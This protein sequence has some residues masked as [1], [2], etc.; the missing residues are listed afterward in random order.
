MFGLPTA[1]SVTPTAITTYF[2]SPGETSVLS[3]PAAFFAGVSSFYLGIGALQ[4][5]QKPK[6]CSLAKTAQDMFVKTQMFMPRG[7]QIDKGT[8]QTVMGYV[9][10]YSPTAD[11]MV[12]QYCK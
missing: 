7:G 1:G 10:Q 11:Q 2:A 5:A 6:S 4:A 9:M 12:K 8:A 3:A